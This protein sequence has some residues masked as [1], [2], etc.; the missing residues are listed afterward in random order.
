MAPSR[1]TTAETETEMGT[2]F[3]A[4]KFLKFDGAAPFDVDGPCKASGLPH[5]PHTRRFVAGH[6][7]SDSCRLLC[8]L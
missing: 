6:V 3:W 7:G 1:A 4:K 2:H 8:Y 5:K